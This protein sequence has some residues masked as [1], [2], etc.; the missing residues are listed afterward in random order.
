MTTC[1]TGMPSEVV[2]YVKIRGYQHVDEH[3]TDF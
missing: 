1:N 3:D 2:R